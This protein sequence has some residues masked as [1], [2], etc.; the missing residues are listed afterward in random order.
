MKYNAYYQFMDIDDL[1]A[2]INLQYLVTHN[3]DDRVPA[4]DFYKDL[5]RW[6]TNK[7]LYVPTK[8]EVYEDLLTLGFEKNMGNVGERHHITV[9]RGLK[10]K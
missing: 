2:F 10:N 9:I 7:A 1:K 8:R 5:F 6:G 3:Y 4:Y